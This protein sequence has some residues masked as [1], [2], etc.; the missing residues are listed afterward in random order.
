M[1]LLDNKESCTSLCML[2]F[3]AVDKLVGPISCQPLI[4]AET[5]LFT[6]P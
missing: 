5:T 1:M 2:L 4:T 6:Y 3:Y